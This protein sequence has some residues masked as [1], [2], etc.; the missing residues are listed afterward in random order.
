VVIAPIHGT[1]GKCRIKG[2]GC[3]DWGM[4]YPS[5]Q[6]REH[7]T[8]C[9]RISACGWAVMAAMQSQDSVGCMYNIIHVIKFCHRGSMR[10]KRPKAAPVG[11]W[12]CS[13]F[14]PHVDFVPQQ[15]KIDGLGQQPGRAAFDR[16]APGLGIAIGGNHDDGN[17]GPHLS[18]LG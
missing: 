6:R 1:P 10:K 14:E 4:V 9:H 11:R 15:R 16:L 17:V 8:L 7:N 13:P 5:D 3:F 18:C 2:S 12:S